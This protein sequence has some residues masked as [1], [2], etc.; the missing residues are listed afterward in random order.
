MLGG[1]QVIFCRIIQGWSQAQGTTC[2]GAQKGLPYKAI[3][4]VHPFR[5]P[6][7]P[8]TQAI[9]AL[10]RG[11]TNPAPGELP[12]RRQGPASAG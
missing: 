9:R 4:T 8:N 1:Y 2:L 5:S 10:N 12:E 7:A 6:F 11:E 3:A